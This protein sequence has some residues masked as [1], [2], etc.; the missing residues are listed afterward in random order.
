MASKYIK[1]LALLIYSFIFFLFI[2]FL[3]RG[4][5]ALLSYYNHGYLNF[6]FSEI[7]RVTI[8]SFIAGT[9]VWLYS[10]VI[11]FLDWVKSRKLRSSDPE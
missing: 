10:L 5:I 8:F 1:S 9:A 7:K 2:G 6:P 3:S 4:V 11:H